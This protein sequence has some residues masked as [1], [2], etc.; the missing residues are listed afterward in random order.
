MNNTLSAAGHGPCDRWPTSRTSQGAT[1]FRCSPSKIS[2]DPEWELAYE[3]FETAEEEVRKFVGRLKSMQLHHLPKAS[4]VVEIFCGRGNGL[5]ALERLGFVN[6]EG[7]D[8]SERLLSK[9]A[10][11]PLNLYLADCRQL[12]FEDHSRDLVIV[13]GGL[14]HLPLLPDDVDQTL[15]EV[16]RVL[17]PGGRLAIVE[18]YPTRT[19]A[20]IHRIS[21]QKVVRAMSPRL[22]ALATM[23][24]RERTT[25]EPWL[26]KIPSIRR[27]IRQ[28]FTPLVDR[29]SWTKWMF[30]GQ[31]P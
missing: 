18:P 25:Y 29:I 2:C 16:K 5:V 21:E 15:G 14:H 27:S 6:R 20:W 3:R 7:V 11:A 30:V 22:D 12:P 23:T 10:G 24:E 17:R 8:L 19:L 9:Y 28:A 4:R 13:Q 26:Q 31:A 1:I